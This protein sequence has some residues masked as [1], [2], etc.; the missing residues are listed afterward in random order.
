[1][2]EAPI[3]HIVLD[4]RGVPYVADTGMKVAHLAIDATVWGLQP[5]AIHK[6]YPNLTI[7]QI[8]AAL[9]YYYDHKHEIDRLIAEDE[10]KYLATRSRFPNRLTRMDFEQRLQ[11]FD[12]RV[13]FLPI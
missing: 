9:S 8:H 6:N 11:D 2:V 1:M 5:E 7:G 4:D 3:N 12:G 13:Y 10:E